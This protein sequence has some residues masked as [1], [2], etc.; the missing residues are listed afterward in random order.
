MMAITL[1]FIYSFALIQTQQTK[2]ESKNVESLILKQQ[3]HDMH[4]I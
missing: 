2:R 3:Q 1:L 4:V